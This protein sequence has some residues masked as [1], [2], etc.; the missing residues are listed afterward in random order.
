MLTEGRTWV[1]DLQQ[2]VRLMQPLLAQLQRY[3]SAVLEP[4]HDAGTLQVL[5]RRMQ[6][7]L[8]G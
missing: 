6:A 4:G 7:H 8:S 1:Q 3:D 5:V 2:L